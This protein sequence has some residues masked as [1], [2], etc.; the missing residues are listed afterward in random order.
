VSLHPTPFVLGILVGVG[1]LTKASTLFLVAIVPL[2]IVLKWWMEPK[3]AGAV[4]A[5]RAS[6]LHTRL[7]LFAAPA[8]LLGLIWWARNLGVYGW[9]DFLGLRRHDMV[10]A[11]QP[12][13]ADFIADNGWQVY[14][15]RAFG[16]TFNSFWGQFGW[17]ALP[18]P[19]WIYRVFQILLV[20]AAS[21]WVMDGV[22]MKRKRARTPPP[23]PLSIHGEGESGDSQ[24]AL[25]QVQAGTNRAAWVILTLT[26]ILAVLAFVY[27]NTEFLQHQG[28]YLFPALIPFV[29]WIPLGVDAWRLLLL[30]SNGRG[31]P[32]VRPYARWFTA[33]M[34]LPLA[35]LDVY[36]LWRV[37]VPGLSP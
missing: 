14:L 15:N 29:L 31:E 30:G 19:P 20:M 9:P 27:Y 4:E 1:F 24:P 23:S 16:E 13:T 21:G 18:M 35:L 5:R 36:L 17:M 28:R 34:F 3:D 12:R 33:A 22:V 37:I 32:A 26:A 8:L 11:D 6:P 2:A 25:P 7:I 10:V